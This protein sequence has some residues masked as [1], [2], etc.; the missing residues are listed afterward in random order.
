M[1]FCI[2]I[3]PFVHKAHENTFDWVWTVKLFWLDNDWLTSGWVEIKNYGLNGKEF[4][5]AMAPQYE[6]E[7][8]EHSN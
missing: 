7:F 6:I 3:Y 4:C 2:K 5:H 8:S 1:M